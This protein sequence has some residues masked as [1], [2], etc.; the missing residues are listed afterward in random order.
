MI[1][2]SNCSKKKVEDQSKI[3]EEIILQ[4]ISDNNLDALKGEEG[5]YYVIDAPG[6]GDPCF[7][8]SEVKTTYKG[9]F[10]DGSVFDEGTIDNFF[11]TNAIKGWQLG[12]PK[13]KEGGKGMLL[14][15]SAIGYGPSGSSSGSIP[16]NSVILFD[17]DLIKVY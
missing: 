6:T 17:I 4:Y 12:I 14:I 3:D 16:P 7:F 11:L 13:Y 10:T 1:G 15:P 9:Y 8:N 5:L 2:F